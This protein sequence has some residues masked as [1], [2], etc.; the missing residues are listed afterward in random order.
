MI[1]IILTSVRI[2][3]YWFTVTLPT[4]GQ[5][6]PNHADKCPHSTIVSFNLSLYISW[7]N[8]FSLQLQQS[9]LFFLHSVHVYNCLTFCENS[10]LLQWRE[11]LIQGINS[12]NSRNIKWTL[13]FCKYRNRFVE[14][15]GTEFRKHPAGVLNKGTRACLLFRALDLKKERMRKK[16]SGQMEPFWPQEGT[17]TYLLCVQTVITPAGGLILPHPWNCS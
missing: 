9:Q 17:H 4:K 14:T 8:L 11:P 10:Y 7:T 12:I 5:V 2:N 13:Y 15:R 16:G 1:D 6:E 3:L